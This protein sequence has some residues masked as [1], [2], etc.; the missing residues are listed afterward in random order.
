VQTMMRS[1]I[2]VPS[3]DLATQL[4]CPHPGTPSD[5]H[6]G[7]RSRPLHPIAERQVWLD[8]QHRAAVHYICTAQH[9][10]AAAHSLHAG[11]AEP[12]GAGAVGGA[13][14]QHAARLAVESGHAHLS[15]GGGVCLALVL[16]GLWW[17]RGG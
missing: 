4:P 7:W 9:Q 1:L 11:H 5:P 15:R 2:T 12:D 6:P 16:C 10:R 14:G 17:D 3:K 13:R 8:V